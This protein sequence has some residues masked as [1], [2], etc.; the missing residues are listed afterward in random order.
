MGFGSQAFGSGAAGS[1]T[2]AAVLTA[3]QV[4]RT[5]IRV[6][7]SSSTPRE[8]PGTV[9]DALYD[10]GWQLAAPRNVSAPV[11]RVVWVTREEGHSVLLHLDAPLAGPDE[12]YEVIGSV[13]LFGTPRSTRTARFR[14]F[15]EARGVRSTAARSRSFDLAN[16]QAGQA[17]PGTSPALG[18]LMLDADGDFATDAG[19]AT[20]KKRVI[21]RLTTPLGA[22]RHMPDYGMR[23]TFKGP[24]TAGVLRDLQAQAIRQV[25]LELGVT[26][27][28]VGLSTSA[29]G[30][31]LLEVGVSAQ[32][33]NF[34][35][36]VET[37]VGE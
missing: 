20:L 3:V 31:V 13:A 4:T 32:G 33:V 30:V 27:V 18:T 26:D 23:L 12:L 9:R 6:G 11:P 17:E 37:P 15:G 24:V 10:R 7:V 1:G 5:S 34:D 14:T 36:N 25:R 21:R 35:V 2:A 16:Q 22:F 29:P 8:N 28:R 19:I